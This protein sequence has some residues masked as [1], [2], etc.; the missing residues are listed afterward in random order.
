MLRSPGYLK[1]LLLAALIGVPVSLVA[2]GFLSLEHE[3]Q[4]WVWESLPDRLGF[5]RAP[6]W[7]PLPTLALAGVL[8][9]PVLRWMT[10]HGGHLPVKGLGGPPQ[11][12]KALPSVV[13]AALIALPLGTSLG[14][15]VPLMA[16]GSGLALMAAARAQR[17]DRPKAAAIVGTAGSTAA[18][19]T[20]FGNPVVGCVM[21]LEAAGLGGPQ[22]LLLVLPCLVASGVGALVF[23]GFGHWTGLGIGALALPS[24]PPSGTPDAG[25]FLW[26]VPIA[27]L[28]AAVVVGAQS[29]GWSTAAFTRQYTPSR[30]VV[31]AVLVGVC[32][33]AYALFTGRSPE[34]AALSG[35]VM[36]GQLAADPHAWGVGALAL[37]VLCKGLALGVSLGSLRGGPIFPVVLIGAAVG[38]ACSGLPGLGTAAGLSIGLAASGAAITGLPVTATLLAV[39]LVG[40]NAPNAA[41]L[42]IVSTAVSFLVATLLKRRA[43]AL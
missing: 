27:A 41:P 43:P 18:I 8:V 34:E 31:C 4:H 15:E 2:F 32:T 29:L 11:P 13:L 14:P 19:A 40:D 1:L 17:E 10:G 5:A 25:E 28:I 35:Q 39:L 26:A 6:W 16:I 22:L 23:T 12:P 36:L 24:L 20:V 37:L 9:A 38:I 42:M 21:V 33:A 30:T 7:W 3:L